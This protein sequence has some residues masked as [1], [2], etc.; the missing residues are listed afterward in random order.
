MRATRITLALAALGLVAAACA[1]GC[2]REV[3]EALPAAKPQA[4]SVPLPEWAPKNPSP[5]FLR[6]AAVIESDPPEF[7]EKSGEPDAAVRAYWGRFTRWLPTAWELFGTLTDEQIEQFLTAGEAR[8]PVRSLTEKQ[9]AILSRLFD[10]YRRAMKGVPEME[11]WLV[12][13]YKLGAREDLSNVDVLFRNRA[14]GLA[15]L[16]FR[17]PQP[18]G[19]PLYSPA[20]LGLVRSREKD[21]DG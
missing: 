10:D 7:F 9:Q 4:E 5:E 3:Q 2:G 17:V 8:I 15:V 6:A 21:A 16:V 1:A 19:D 13:L 18:S 11:D 12:E 14:G 20:R